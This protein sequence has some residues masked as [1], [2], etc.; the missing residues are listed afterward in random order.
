M[1][2]NLPVATSLSIASPGSFPAI[3]RWRQLN[4]S[5]TKGFPA[6]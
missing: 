6:F 3:I 4:G 2:V 5:T 1:I